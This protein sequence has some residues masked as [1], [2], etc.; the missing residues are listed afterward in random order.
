MFGALKHLR[1]RHSR[2]VSAYLPP[3]LSREN[4]A[5]IGKYN[6][7]ET[8]EYLASVVMVPGN[9]QISKED[10]GPLQYSPSCCQIFVTND[11]YPYT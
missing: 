2:V 7:Y 4:D 10:P 5:K 6:F 1:F 8:I 11:S 9:R 3:V